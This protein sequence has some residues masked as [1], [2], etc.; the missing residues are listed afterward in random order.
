MKHISVSPDPT[1]TPS[2]SFDSQLFQGNAFGAAGD[3]NVFPIALNVIKQ[4]RLK[5]LLF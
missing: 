4:N 5:N 1:S 3:P 2:L